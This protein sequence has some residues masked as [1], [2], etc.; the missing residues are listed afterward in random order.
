MTAYRWNTVLVMAAAA[1]AAGC[2]AKSAGGAPASGAALNT[3]TLNATDVALARVQTLRAGIPL[4]GALEA[5][6]KITVGAPLAEQLIE[7]YVNEGDRCRR[8]AAGALRPAP[9][10][11]H[12]GRHT[13]E[14]SPPIGCHRTLFL[15]CP[16]TTRVW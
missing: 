8:R 15:C 4:S 7:V 2:G 3:A 6:V 1:S 14:G 5:K 9:G 10:R 13:Q 16:L 11:A 12:R